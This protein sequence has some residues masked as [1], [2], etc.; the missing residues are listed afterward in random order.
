MSASKKFR[1]VVEQV[2]R[3]NHEMIL[4]DDNLMSAL[5]RARDMVSKRNEHSKSTGNFYSVKKIEEMKDE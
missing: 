3:D 4:E 1:I 5:D 2:K